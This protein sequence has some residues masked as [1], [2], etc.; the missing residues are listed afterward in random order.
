MFALKKAD[1][2]VWGAE[3]L[4]ASGGRGRPTTKALADRAH[5]PSFFTARY[6]RRT[7][8][9]AWFSLKSAITVLNHQ[10]SSVVMLYDSMFTY[11]R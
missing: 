5:H 6:F 9:V 1:R 3:R 11:A 7:K 8:Q 2:P 4:S 10:A